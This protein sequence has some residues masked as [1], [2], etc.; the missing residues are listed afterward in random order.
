[1]HPQRTHVPPRP[2]RSMTAVERPSWAHR[3]APTYPAGPPP[4]KITSNEAIKSVRLD[5]EFRAEA[6][7]A[8]V[9]NHAGL[10][11]RSAAARNHDGLDARSAEVRNH[12][13]W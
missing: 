11:A 12:A 5:A 4:R 1:M 13:C 6:R 7:S 3:M 9:R 10:E 2:S 8:E